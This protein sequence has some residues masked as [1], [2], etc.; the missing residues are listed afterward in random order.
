MKALKSALHLGSKD[1]HKRHKG[2]VRHR[3]SRRVYSNELEDFAAEGNDFLCT[4]WRE[5]KD[6]RGQAYDGTMT[7]R[8]H[9]V[10]F[11]SEDKE[12]ELHV[13]LWE[14]DAIKW[15]IDQSSSFQNS[16][17]VE[18]HGRKYQFTGFL[19]VGLA[20]RT[21]KHA[22]ETTL[23][24]EGFGDVTDGASHKDRKPQLLQETV[25]DK[26]HDQE[27]VQ[28]A[29]V[30][31]GTTILPELQPNYDEPTNV[32]GEV[33]LVSAFTAS[34]TSSPPSS[35]DISER[36]P[37]EVQQVK[38]PREVVEVVGDGYEATAEVGE[39]KEIKRKPRRK[40]VIERNDEGAE[41][42][43][44]VVEKED[45][46]EEKDIIVNEDE[47]RAKVSSSRPR[48]AKLPPVARSV[49]IKPP[50]KTR[51]PDLE[52]ILHMDLPSFW[53]WFIQP[54]NNH[55]I[56]VHELKKDR[57]LT[58]GEWRATS[59]GFIQR[60][61]SVESDVNSRLSSGPVHTSYKQNVC[62]SENSRDLLIGTITTSKGVPYSNFFNVV[63]YV[64]FSP[65]DVDKLA[66]KFY[67]RVNWKAEPRLIKS[68][69]E[70]RMLSNIM[71]Y[72]SLWIRSAQTR[73]SN[74]A[75]LDSGSFS[76]SSSSD[77]INNLTAQQNEEALLSDDEDEEATE[78]APLPPLTAGIKDEIEKEEGRKDMQQW[79]IQR[80]QQMLMEVLNE[81]LEWAMQHRRFVVT[82]LMILLVV[83]IAWVC[84]PR[85]AFV[86]LSMHHPPSASSSPSPSLPPSLQEAVASSSTLE[87][88]K[89]ELL[90]ELWK[91]R[92]RQK[93]FTEDQELSEMKAAS[94]QQQKR[95]ASITEGEEEKAE[96]AKR[97]Y[98]PKE[99][100]MMMERW[101]LRA[102]M[103]EKMLEALQSD[104][105]SMNS[106]VANKR[107]T[108]E[109]EPQ[110]W[111]AQDKEAG[112]RKG[113]FL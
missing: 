32:A 79:A 74:K 27:T 77:D 52:A 82:C 92:L 31:Q 15:E 39:K 94:T 101:R 83:A 54:R 50:K 76:P 62:L 3:S 53:T 65:L 102:E 105:H 35:A 9:S 96:D 21:L 80:N 25:I 113:F 78:C 42:E 43:V 55:F 24:E 111:M 51:T 38:K 112:K 100:E 28:V 110:A 13:G 87:G 33:S 95:K 44:F 49:G 46:D 37:R 56:H 30:Q 19:D 7:V 23:Q 2:G 48:Q 57:V 26:I 16:I 75:Y 1:K 70:K 106:P 91:E 98:S 36:K 93:Y 104:I 108:L 89:A 86:S 85:M 4:H 10:T 8:S 71:D 58:V 18:S 61:M 73:I 40:E 12:F 64:I 97:N 45:A 14:V 29:P 69:L 63:T 99:V 60:K 109:E 103:A 67:F 68:Y 17:I 6:Q 81:A 88:L 11:R 47:N 20:Y 84:Y 22:W 107:V 41:G 59:R 34:S 90:K 66:V 5:V 72:H